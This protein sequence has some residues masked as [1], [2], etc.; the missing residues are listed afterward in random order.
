M[1]RIR[2]LVE[3]AI[4]EAPF[5]REL[6]VRTLELAPDRARLGLPFRPELATLGDLVHGGAIAALADVAATAACWCCAE[7][8]PGARGT[9][10]GCSIQYL[11][12]ARGKD[13]VAEARVV[14]RGGSI[15][16]CDVEVSDASGLPVARA[17]V[18]YKL[19]RGEPRSGPEPTAPSR[20]GRP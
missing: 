18:T 11:E 9:T 8:A 2:R 3:T 12:A 13:L 20:S 14:R 17:S 1:D 19:S 4:V 5:A 10:I 15:V 16:F 6:G 7:L